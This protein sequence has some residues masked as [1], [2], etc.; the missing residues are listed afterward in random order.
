LQ[1]EFRSARSHSAHGGSD[2]TPY[3]T[4]SFDHAGYYETRALLM[5]VGLA[6]SLYFWI[7]R[8]DANYLVMF[9]SGV[10][11]QGL[12]EY[13]LITGGLRGPDYSLSVFGLQLPG[14]VSWI[15]QGFAE[16][17]I[18]AMMGYMYLDAFEL[19]LE[20]RSRRKLWAGLCLLIVALATL[21]GFLAQGQPV[22]SARPMFSP[23][24]MFFG[25]AWIVV[26][27]VL[28]WFKG[29]NGFRL[30]GYWYAGLAIYVLLT[31]EPLHLLGARYVSFR[32]ASGAFVPAAGWDGWRWI[33]WSHFYEV[34]G[35]KIYYFIA[36]FV[37]GLLRVSRRWDG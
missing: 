15:F 12:M 35:T 28:L 13:R 16:G 19:N 11:F 20:D 6:V 36:P 26:A 5:L 1:K 31:F 37:F 33:F 8:G 34:A 18:L 29:G 14:R 21:V 17:G 25:I 32:D 27:L 9:L 23:E 30:F 24:S 3:L 7:R 2:L 10:F 4:R 22:S